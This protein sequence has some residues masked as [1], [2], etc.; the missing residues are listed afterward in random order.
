[1]LAAMARAGAGGTGIP[2]PG[3]VPHEDAILAGRSTAPGAVQPD[4]NKILLA[5]KSGQGSAES[6]VQL[7]ALLSGLGG[8]VPTGAGPDDGDGGDA[9]GAGDSDSGQGTIAQA[10]A[11]M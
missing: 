11:G 5:I 8:G 2:Q 1:M 9:E 7:L 3:A 4:L 6:L 10:Y